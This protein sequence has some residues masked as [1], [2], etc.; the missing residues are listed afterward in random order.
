MS[1]YLP[2]CKV[3]LYLVFILYRKIPQNIV[4][5]KY[6]LILFFNVK[7]IYFYLC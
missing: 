7:Y 6:I 2:N 3:Y 1:V 4:I 5:K